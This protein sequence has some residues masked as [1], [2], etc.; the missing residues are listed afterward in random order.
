VCVCVC[1]CVRACVFLCVCG[2]NARSTASSGIALAYQLAPPLIRLGARSRERV[3][4]VLGSIPPAT[5]VPRE[6]FPAPKFHSV[7]AADTGK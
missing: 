5:G 2:Q 4:V 7:G 1:V 3:L 6:D